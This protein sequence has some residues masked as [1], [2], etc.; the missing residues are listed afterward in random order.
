MNIEVS[1]QDYGN[2]M[3]EKSVIVCSF[4]NNAHLYD[5]KSKY[6]QKSCRPKFQRASYCNDILLP[7]VDYFYFDNDNSRY[8]VNCTNCMLSINKCRFLLRFIRLFVR[9][10]IYLSDLFRKIM[11]TIGKSKVREYFNVVTNR[12]LLFCKKT[13]QK[14]KVVSVVDT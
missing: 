9:Q 13:L 4:C 14:T 6:M 7:V 1:N 8:V 2:I 11:S 3:F 5:V 10:E 12:V